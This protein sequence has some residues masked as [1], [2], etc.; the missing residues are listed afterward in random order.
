M[1]PHPTALPYGD[2]HS[3]SWWGKDKRK[4]NKSTGTD[5]VDNDGRNNPTSSIYAKTHPAQDAHF[6]SPMVHPSTGE[7]ITSYKCL[8][9]NPKT[10][11]LWKMAFGKDFGGMV[12]GENKSGQI[13]TN[14]VFVMTW[15]DIDNAIAAGNK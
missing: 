4:I 6:A 2:I 11:N 9:N 3:C 13:G 5:H 8:M 7:A 12:Q 15:D 14:S 1:F 10:T